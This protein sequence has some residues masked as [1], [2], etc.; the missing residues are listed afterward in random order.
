MVIHQLVFHILTAS[1]P[2]ENDA[3]EFEGAVSSL[4]TI[5]RSRTLITGHVPSTLALIYVPA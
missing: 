2:G 4:Q 3:I 1:P 5:I